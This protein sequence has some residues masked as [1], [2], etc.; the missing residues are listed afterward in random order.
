MKTFWDERYSSE[1]YIYGKEP[2]EFFAEQIRRLGPGMI[3]LPAE[4]EG[5]NAVYA[6][7]IGWKVHAFDSSSVGAAKA[8]D[9]AAEKN[10]NILY[11]ISDIETFEPGDFK[12]D[13]IGFQL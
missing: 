13:V 3:L 4:G 10:V 7:Q 5:R 11:A 2:N 8:L 12:Y 9:L 6:A 1:E